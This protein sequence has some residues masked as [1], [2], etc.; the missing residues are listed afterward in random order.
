MG[1]ASAKKEIELEKEVMNDLK[2]EQQEAHMDTHKPPECVAF[3]SEFPFPITVEMGCWANDDAEAPDA[4]VCS[5]KGD[6]VDTKLI[7]GFE[8][9][10][11]MAEDSCLLVVHTKSDAATTEPKTNNGRLRNRRV[12]RLSSKRR[13]LNAEDN[14][15]IAGRIDIRVTAKATDPHTIATLEALETGLSTK[16]MELGYLKQRIGTDAEKGD[17][18]DFYLEETNN[19]LNGATPE[20]TLTFA[21]TKRAYMET[22]EIK[23]IFPRATFEATSGSFGTRKELICD[24]KFSVE[25]PEATAHRHGAREERPDVEDVKDTSGPRTSGP[26]DL[27]KTEDEPRCCKKDIDFDAQDKCCT[28]QGG[29]FTKEDRKKETLEFAEKEI[30]EAERKFETE[31]LAKREKEAQK[32]VIDA[33]IKEV[34]A[35]TAVLETDKVVLETKI[36]AIDAET[37]ELQTEVA[38]IEAETVELATEVAAIELV[39]GTL[40]NDLT[41]I[42]ADKYDLEATEANLH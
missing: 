10:Y 5:G 28:A 40:Q 8:I 22:G 25:T 33:Q 39:A 2:Q 20:D 19:V 27:I 1:M 34:E 17:Y 3:K 6:V 23:D 24:D 9:T 12:R 35:E 4:Q 16:P 13:T 41:Q 29:C 30:V 31:T 32:I 11:H 7:P 38:A 26:C 15:K 42:A 18:F 14:V 36:A 21:F 37:V